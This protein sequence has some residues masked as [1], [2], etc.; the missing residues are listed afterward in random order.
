MLKPRL[1]NDTAKENE[2]KAGQVSVNVSGTV[3]GCTWC[4]LSGHLYKKSC[5]EMYF[6]AQEST[7]HI[8][9]HATRN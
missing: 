6:M 1:E 5:T 9:D 4:H 2:E 3:H 7:E 8:P